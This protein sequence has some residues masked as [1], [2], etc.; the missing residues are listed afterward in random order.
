MNEN[1][2]ISIKQTLESLEDDE[3][4]V[5]L[6]LLSQAAGRGDLT[7]P[8]RSGPQYFDFLADSLIKEP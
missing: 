2:T 5:V 1:I 4:M 3:N 8:W 6:W 7:L